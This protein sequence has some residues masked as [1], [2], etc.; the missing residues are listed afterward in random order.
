M[1]TFVVE[2]VLGSPPIPQPR[3]RITTR[4]KHAHAYIPKGHAVHAW[5]ALI[6]KTLL[7]KYHGPLWCGPVDCYISFIIPR[8]KAHYGTGKNCL[9]L[10][11]SAPRDP[12]TANTGDLDNLLKAIWDAC[13]GILYANDSQIVRVSSVK[14]YAKPSRE[15]GVRATF[16]GHDHTRTVTR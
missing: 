11:A 12:T 13:E 6:Q 2:L 9:K 7:N 4:G 10:K 8:P 16:E 14:V 1:G 3:H 15:A 5:K